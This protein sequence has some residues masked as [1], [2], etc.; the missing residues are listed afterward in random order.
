VKP[1]RIL[2]ADDHA[3]V[4]EGL[5]RILDRPEFEVVGV[6]DDGCTLLQ[7]AIRLQPDVI[8][9]DIVMPS[10]N[11]IEAT[12]KIHA[13]N[14]K[15]KIIFLTMR[16][17]S[18]YASAAFAAGASGYV[19]KS[20]AGEDLIVAISEALNGRTYISKQIAAERGK[21]PDG[22]TRRQREV[23][24]CLAKGLQTKE[25]AAMMALSSRTVEFHKYRLMETLGARSVA[26]LT[27]YAVKH[28]IIE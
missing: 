24:Q 7:A 4:I 12:R 25:I 20:D 9:C 2:L 22:L 28:G 3:V 8:V 18:A 15:P 11:G 13:E 10:L 27:R 19:L 1:W 16:P 21:D 6:A 5:R 26:D 14:L 17:E 23:L